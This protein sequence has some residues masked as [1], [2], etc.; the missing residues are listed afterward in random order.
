[1][2]R[3]F[4]LAL[5]AFPLLAA[6]VWAGSD[7]CS[8]S[9]SYGTT[10]GIPAMRFDFGGRLWYK[11]AC[12]GGYCCSPCGGGASGVYGGGGGGCGGPQLGPWYNYWPLEAHFQVPAI[13]QYPYWPAPQTLP[14]GMAAG[15]HGPANFHAPVAPVGYSPPYWYGH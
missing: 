5:L 13:P 8:G 11:F 12:G 2:K 6:P 1:M 3:L 4:G 10:I 9:Y 7:S 14:P 15:G